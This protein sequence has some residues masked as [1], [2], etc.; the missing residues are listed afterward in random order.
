MTARL[1]AFM[2]TL[3]QLLKTCKQRQLTP[4][5]YPQDYN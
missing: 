2:T 1:Q 3:H 4:W 5:K